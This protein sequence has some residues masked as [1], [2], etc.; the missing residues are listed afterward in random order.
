MKRLVALLDM[1]VN[2]LTES[3]TF[4]SACILSR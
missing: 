3:R 2:M 4:G 1:L